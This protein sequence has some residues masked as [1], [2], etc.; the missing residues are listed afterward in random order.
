MNSSST[1]WNNVDQY[2]TARPADVAERLHAIRQ[3]VMSVA[4]EAQEGISYGMPGYKLYGKP[5]IYFA[6]FQ[7]HIGVYATPSWHAAFAK[8][9]AH[10][11]QGKW[12]VQFPLGEK[13][14]LG[15]IKRMIQW[16]MR[17]I[18]QK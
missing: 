6:A 13:L 8:E 3:T 17:E 7:K 18:T 2:I 9:L 12:S 15:L 1:K 5:L 11:K 16:K 10:Y 4:P 14:P